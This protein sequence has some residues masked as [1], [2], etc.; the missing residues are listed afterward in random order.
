MI[1]CILLDRSINWYK[2]CVFVKGELYGHLFADERE[3]HSWIY[4]FVEDELLKE[5]IYD[6]TRVIYVVAC[7]RSDFLVGVVQLMYCNFFII[8]IVMFCP[9]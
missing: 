6:E 1:T 9:F 4:F 3:V 2:F 8:R 7:K 5:M